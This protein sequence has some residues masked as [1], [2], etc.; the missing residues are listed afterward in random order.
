MQ[1]REN[2]S[3]RC[4]VPVHSPFSRFPSTENSFRHLQERCLHQR[5]LGP[6]QRHPTTSITLP[7]RIPLPLSNDDRPTFIR[8]LFNHTET[9]SRYHQSRS[10]TRA[11]RRHQ[12]T[13]PLSLHLLLHHAT[14]TNTRH[15]F[16][17]FLPL[18]FPQTDNAPLH[19]LPPVNSEIVISNNFRDH[20]PMFPIFIR[21]T[22]RR[23]QRT[24][25]LPLGL[26]S[27]PIPL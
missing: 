16:L 27:Q 21:K 24:S 20:S 2:S 25:S 6:R 15:L 23:C 7:F 17:H 4:H 3:Q 19:C 12:C 11:L 13:T 14:H 18:P 5:R 22:A 26:H 9:N 10:T 8:T 1:E